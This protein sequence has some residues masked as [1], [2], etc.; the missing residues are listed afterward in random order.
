MKKIYYHHGL[1]SVLSLFF[2]T[3]SKLHSSTKLEY[4]L[5]QMYR[6]NVTKSLQIYLELRRLTVFFYKGNKMYP[7]DVV[8]DR[9]ESGCVR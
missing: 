9:S 3:P 5:T 8:I 4:F 2:Y 6:R 1:V 7:L